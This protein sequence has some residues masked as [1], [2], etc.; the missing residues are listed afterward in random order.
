MISD[1]PA[2]KVGGIPSIPRNLVMSIRQTTDEQHSRAQQVENLINTYGVQ[3]F[4]ARL[5]EFLDWGETWSSE[6]QEY[7][8][9]K[10]AHSIA[11]DECK[12]AEVQVERLQAVFRKTNL[13]KDARAWDRA[14]ESHRKAL[15][16]L[17]KCRGR[18]DATPRNAGNNPWTRLK[19]PSGKHRSD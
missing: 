8:D 4:E 15:A 5:K 13:K 1:A 10:K 16:R 7:S 19:A 14:K 9:A 17:T 11:F 18:E 2:P 12:N 6:T 3:P